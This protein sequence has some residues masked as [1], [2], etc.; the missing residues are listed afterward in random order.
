M[1]RRL[2]QFANARKTRWRHLD[3][4]SDRTADVSKSS[5]PG[6]LDPLPAGIVASSVTPFTGE[7]EMDL[8]LLKPHIDWLIAEGADGLSPLGSSGE[9]CALEIEQRKRVL[10]KVIE[11]NNGRVARMGRYSPLQHAVDH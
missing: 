4:R 6:S 5:K 10:D 2:Y 8:Q 1:V 3:V 7:G 11:L 9:F